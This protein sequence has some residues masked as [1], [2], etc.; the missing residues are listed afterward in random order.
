MTPLVRDRGEITYS[1]D[2]GIKIK[3][4]SGAVSQV[5]THIVMNFLL[6]CHCLNKKYRIVI[7][8]KLLGDEL[9]LQVTDNRSELKDAQRNIIADPFL[10]QSK[11][12]VDAYK[13]MN[14]VYRLVTER[15]SDYIECDFR[16]REGVCIRIT[17]P[18][19]QS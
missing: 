9:L 12:D 2:R 13:D 6:S 10:Y 7:E 14:I 4:Y 15:L 18:M 1:C 5:L 19:Q 8:A 11:R 3:S 17:V 16:R